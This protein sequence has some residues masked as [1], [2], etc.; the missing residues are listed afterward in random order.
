MPSLLGPGTL[1]AAQNLFLLFCCRFGSDFGIEADCDD[2]EFL[3]NIEL[4]HAQSAFQ[5]GEFFST[6]H[7]AVEVN[8]VQDQWLLTEVFAQP[9]LTAEIISKH[10]V[11]G[12]LLVKILLNTDVLQSRRAQ[13][14]RG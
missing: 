4:K 2:I 9:D 1:V 7:R 14:G 11:C 6:Q 12:H 13:V 5:T 3:T 8:E 10:E